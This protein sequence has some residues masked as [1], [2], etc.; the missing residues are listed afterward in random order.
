M[1]GAATDFE[2]GGVEAE[3]SAGVRY[4]RAAGEYGHLGITRRTFFRWR[5]YGEQA[6]ELPPFDQPGEL[7]GWYHRM[8]DQGHF[9]NAFPRGVRDAIAGAV[10]VPKVK[11]VEEK[12][13][14]SGVPLLGVGEGGA[15]GR[16]AA[17][18]PSSFGA[19]HGDEQGLLYEVAQEENRVAGLRKARDESYLAG[20]KEEGD[21]FARQHADA[22]DNLS[23]IKQRSVKILEQEGKLVPREDVES[24]LAP[25]ITGIVIGGMFLL[26]RIS[27]LLDQATDASERAAIWK[28]AWVEHCQ[29]LMQSRYLPEGM[30]RVPEEVWLEAAQYVQGQVPPPLVLQA[31]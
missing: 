24:D 23:T 17:K 16:E 25:R 27:M 3:S 26:G 19:D 11:V 21:A 12:K 9:K 5:G 15:V 22:L 7:E 2:L 31:A 1:A 13:S 10:P 14:D 6:G 30:T 18:V 4:L 8:K 28:R 20:R 29:P